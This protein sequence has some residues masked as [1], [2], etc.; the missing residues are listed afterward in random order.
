MGLWDPL[1]RMQIMASSGKNGLFGF[2]VFQ[3]FCLKGFHEKILVFLLHDGPVGPRKCGSGFPHLQIQSTCII[4]GQV[5]H[6]RLVDWDC[7]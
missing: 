5:M 3:F 2:Y 1:R 7:L 4:V 6:V